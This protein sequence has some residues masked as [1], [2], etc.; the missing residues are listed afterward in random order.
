MAE[1]CL[2]S[3]PEIHLVDSVQAAVSDVEGGVVVGQ[4]PRPRHLGVLK[5]PRNHTEVDLAFLDCRILFNEREK[6][7]ISDVDEILISYL[8]RLKLQTGLSLKKC[9]K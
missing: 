3:G 8:K 2:S 4:E 7:L 9:N 6:F 5:V 1:G